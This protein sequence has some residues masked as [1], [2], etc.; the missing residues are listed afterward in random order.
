MILVTGATEPARSR[1]RTSTWWR[2]TLTAPQHSS[3]HSR[4]WNVRSSSPAPRDAR[5][6]IRSRSSRR[7]GGAHVVK[8]SQFGADAN[9]PGRFELFVFLITKWSRHTE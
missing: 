4:A 5:K 3:P 8:L 7:R 1:G 2:R 9:S 6:R